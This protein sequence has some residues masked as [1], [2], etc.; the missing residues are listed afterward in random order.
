[1]RKLLFVAAIATVFTLAA[2]PAQA[3]GVSLRLNRSSVPAGGSVRVSGTCEPNSSG[4]VISR[5]FTNNPSRGLEF[6]GVGAVPFT[7]HASGRFSVT[8]TIPSTRRPGTYQVTARCGG[9][10]LGIARSLEVTAAGL[11]FTGPAHAPAEAAV[12]I[13]LLGL[14]G[15]VLLAA[16]RHRVVAG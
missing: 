10:N 6:A 4:F 3:Q 11:P 9:G 15:A 1:M 14:G 2:L 8:A 16:R 13:G 5:A 7:T 12:G